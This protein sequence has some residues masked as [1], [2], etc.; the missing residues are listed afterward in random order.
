VLEFRILGPLE[1][2]GEHGHIRLGGA[3][4]RATLAILLLSANRVVSI[5]RLADDLYAGAAPVTALKQVQRQISE[6]RK[7]LGSASLIETR[8]PGY[9]IRLAPEQL[10][11]TAFERLNG[12]ARDAL[13]GGE[14]QRAADLLRQA[15]GLWRGAPL[16]DLTYES[17]ARAPIERLEE[18]R[19]AAVEQRIEAELAL[20]RHRELVGE[21]E[22]LASEHALR[23]RFRA[24]LML[25]LYRSGRQAEAL[26]AYRRA[27]EALVDDF[28]IEPTPA[29]QQLEHQIL[30]QDPSLELQVLA[31]QRIAP[32]AEHD[33]AVLL[34]PS[35]VG[36][37]DGLLSLADPLAR[38]P[39][40]E[41][42]LA[43]LVGDERELEDA[44]ASVHARREALEVHAR[45]AAFTTVDPAGDVVRLATAHDVE[46]VLVNA[47]LEIDA[48]PLPGDVVTMFERSPAD[49]GIVS[50]TLVEWTQGTGVFVPFGGAEHDWAAL[51]LG[52]WLA[53]V[54]GAPLRL[55]GTGADPRRGQRDASRLL[56]NASLAAQRLVG[57]AGEPLLVE[58]TPSALVAA[59]EEATLV[60]VGVSPRWRRDGIGAVRRTLVREA[61]PPVVL[62]HAGPRPGGLAPRDAR[63]RFSWS[64]EL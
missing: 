10:D 24:Q 58:A 15:L 30:T 19:L 62:V 41:L 14:A 8:S 21:L 6:L 37:L 49:I 35:E 64:L 51:E 42:I 26:E 60:V 3:K 56:A 16:A 11:L 48:T 38:L 20:G 52:A 59:V 7:V 50:G 39:G 53:S 9:T 44:V 46:L 29:L 43:R 2:V 63:T 13:A 23:E 57:V 4:Q 34:V 33:R 45:A 54:V 31:P 32:A 55:V 5:D 12:D 22:E 1:V 28:G 18:I 36:G 17:F 40:R 47:S 27:R 61:R 25:A